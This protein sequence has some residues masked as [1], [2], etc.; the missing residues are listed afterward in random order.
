[1]SFA[2]PV[3]EDKLHLI[4][5]ILHED[6]TARL[7]TVTQKENGYYYDL[8]TLFHKKT[9]VPML[10]NTSFNNQEPIVE[11]PKNALDCFV[12]TNIDYL[13]FVQEQLLVSKK[14]KN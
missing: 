3:K 12:N 7:Q 13:Y 1:M 14:N 2:I 5:A 9:G 10:L 4:P 6:N 8:I 11:T